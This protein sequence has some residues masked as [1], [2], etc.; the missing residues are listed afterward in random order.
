MTKEQELIYARQL[1]VVM[2]RVA[3]LSFI[4]AMCIVIGYIG[5]VAF[6]VRCHA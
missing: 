4:T 2:A 1:G 3:L 6:S 5:V